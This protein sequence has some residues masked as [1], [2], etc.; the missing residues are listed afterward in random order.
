MVLPMNTGVEAVE[1]AIKLARKW[2][3]QTKGI[4]VNQAIILSCTGNFH[5][6]SMAAIS[7]STD[8]Q[9]RTGFGPFLP[10]VGA[11]HDTLTIQYNNLKD[12][13]NVLIKF[14]HYVAGFI[15]EPIQGEAGILIPDEGY[16]AD[17]YNLCHKYN[18]LFIADEVQSGLG[19]SG[20][21]LACDHENVHPDVLILGKA[22]SGGV[23]PVSAVLASKEIMLS[24]GP[25][26]H[27]STFGGNPLASVVAITALKVLKEEGLVEN[28]HIM[29]E[30]LRDG[31][32]ALEN[33]AIKTSNRCTAA[34]FI[35][36]KLGE[37]D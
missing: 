12:L 5:G 11:K 24:I 35:H 2:G 16:L 33:P 28:S 32:K 10:L 29:G 34:H 13:E 21:M 36:L 17:S 30:R 31:L 18:V 6:R 8:P 9:S 19:R 4:P 23:Y 14:G 27:G 25:G 1:T 26:E 7:L 20:K 22:L 15:V 3:Y 37:G